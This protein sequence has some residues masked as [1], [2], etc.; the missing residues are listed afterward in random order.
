MFKKIVIIF[1]MLFSFTLWTNVYALQEDINVD[2]EAEKQDWWILSD[3]D[4]DWYNKTTWY[5]RDWYDRNWYNKDWTH[6]DWDINV[7]WEAEK[8]DWWI[9]SDYNKDWYNKT[10]WYNRD[11]YDKNWFNQDW[12]DK[13]WYDKDWYDED[14]DDR[15]DNWVVDWSEASLYDKDWYNKKTWENRDWL[16]KSQVQ[17]IVNQELNEQANPWLKT[18]GSSETMDALLWITDNNVLGSTKASSNTWWFS[19]LSSLAVW[20]KNSL[21]GLVQIL[22]IWAFLFVW[23]RLAM[24]R[25]NPEEFKKALMHMIYVI[26]WIFIITIAWAAV[27]LVAWINI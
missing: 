14:G 7:D 9:L 1:V 18:L 2:W 17:E 25:W 20:F 5:N 6:I 10:T 8:Q 19:V 13:D 4:K 3:Y 11:W 27:V 12:Y 26:L 16:T 22:A 21:T 15:E 23:I 24:A